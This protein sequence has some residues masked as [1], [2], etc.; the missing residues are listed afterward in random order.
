MKLLTDN[1]KKSL[2]KHPF[3][4]TEML[5]T[6]ARVLV[7]FFNPCGP[8]TWLVTEGEKQKDDTYEFFGYVKLFEDVGWEAGYFTQKEL[9]AVELPFRMKIERDLHCSGTVE[10]LM[11]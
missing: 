9:E 1:I 6:K 3:G 5:G 10:E 2:D 7:K 4:S 8:G 11:D